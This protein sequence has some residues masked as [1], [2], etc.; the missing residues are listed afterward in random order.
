MRRRLSGTRARLTLI[1]AAVL[2]G[3]I[4]LA[5]VALYLALATFERNSVDEVLRS[6]AS[7]ISSAIEDINGQIRFGGGDLPTENQQGIAVDAAIVNRNGSIIQ[8]PAQA[9]STTTLQRLAA[10]AFGSSAPT[11]VN[12]TDHGGS[13]RRMFVQSLKGTVGA[14]AVLVVSRSLVELNANLN[15]LLLF[16]GIFSAL[17]V[18]GGAVLAHWLTGRVLIP[19]RRI[20]SLARS[21]GQADLHRRVEVVVPPDELGELVETFNGMLARLESS[22]ESLRRFTADASHELRSPLTIMRSELEVTR[23]RP[24]TAAEYERALDEMET[25]VEHMGRLVD[26]LLMLARA[27]AGAL[28][29]A[30]VSVD[31]ADFLEEIGA[32]WSSAAQRRGV[33]IRVEVPVDGTV[34]LDP[35]LIRRSLDN[36]IDNAIRHAPDGSTVSLA[37]LRDGQ[38]WRID[39]RDEGPGVPPAARTRIFERFARLDGAR[40]K[41]TGGVGLGLALSR[42]IVES[43]GGHLDL[44]NGNGHGA[45]FRVELPQTPVG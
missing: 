14:D 32:R 41:D 39:V 27:D 20:A 11:L 9:F 45:T 30:R 25:E 22:F 12:G 13:P 19:V 40:N 35:D 2:A 37:A 44:V 33:R 3:A 4:L 10:P 16:L 34:S 36:L 18:L 23:S 5:D 8:T 21:F 6:Q 38:A 28:K 26:R 1:H 15:R 7:T 31:A 17:I 24:R 43:H 29:P 42:A